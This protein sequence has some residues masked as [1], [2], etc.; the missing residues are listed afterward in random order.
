MIRFLTV[1]SIT[2]LFSSNAFA[3]ACPASSE[4][5]GS[6]SADGSNCTVTG[7]NSTFQLNFIAGFTDTTTISAAGGNNGTTIGAQRKLSFI[8][9]AEILADQI[10]STQT[11][12]V[13]AKF[14]NTLTCDS[15][16][17]TLGSAGASVNSYYPTPPAGITANTW[18][19]VGL[20]NDKA[21]SD[22]FSPAADALGPYGD[23]SESYTGNS[24]GSDINAKFNTDLGDS[25]C[26]SGSNGWY[27]G[28]DSPPSNYIGFVTVL[29]HEMVHGFGF[30]S[31][32]NKS[33]GSK[34]GGLDDIFSNFLYDLNNG[35]WPSLTPAQRADSVVSVTGLLWNGT[36]VN[37]QA[38]GLLTDGFQDNDSSS[39]FT[40]GDRIQMY[41]PNSVEGGSSVSH[42]NTDAS[43][44]ELMEP[45]YT[46]GSLSIGLALYLLQDIG[47]S[48]TA[49]T[50][51]NAPTI[52]AVDQST[53]E[54]TAL[55]IDI[56][57][58][59]LD[60]ADDTDG[61][62]LT[63]TV[64][65]C[66]TNIACSINTDGTNFVMT[67]A[68]NHNGGTHTIT[69]NVSDGNGGTD[70]DTF[71]LNVIAQNDAPQWSTIS[72]QTVNYGTPVDINLSSFASDQEGDSLNYSAT[73]CGT[74]LTC[75]I[76]GS[77]LTLTASSN[78]GN[79]VGVTIQ[80]DDGNSGQTS[81]SF[82]VNITNTAPVLSSIGNQA[83][84]VN[85]NLVVT[86]SA[87]DGEENALT[88]S[89][90]SDA[91]N[92]ATVSGTILTL[93]SAAIG[94]FSVTVQVSDGA[95]TDSE[96]FTF[97]VYPEP[98]LD[99]NSTTL[100]PNDNTN[101]SNSNTVLDISSVNGAYQYSLDF[102]GNNVDSLLSN[103]GT[104]LT[105]GMPTSG[106]FAGEYVLTFTDDNTGDTYD[107]TFVRSP[108][109]VFSATKLLANQS[110]QTLDIEGGAAATTYTLTS[111]E[112]TLTFKNGNSSVTNITGSSDA[113]SFNKA[114]VTL[115]VGNVIAST[116]VDVTVTSTYET[117]DSSGITL[118]PA[119]THTLIIEN[120]NGDALSGANVALNTTNLSAYNLP[121]SYTSNSQGQLSLT[122]PGNTTDYTAVVS[123]SGYSNQSIT[124]DD[125][126]L[127]QTVTMEEITNPMTLAGQVTALEGLSF[128]NELPV[129]TLVLGDSS[130]VNVPVTRTSNNVVTFSY[131][132]NLAISSVS[133][134]EITHSEG[135]GIIFNINSNS[136][137]TF[138]IFMNSST[139]VVTNAPTK[140]GSS[141]GSL[142]AWLFMIL[143][144]LM[145]KPLITRLRNT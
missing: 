76:S 66:A 79:T 44:N 93:S 45:E 123:L 141:G 3:D 136:S 42:F 27:Y 51:N 57:S 119:R 84:P 35:P 41:A 31:L 75:D 13:D 127:T 78:A 23:S 72:T 32:V 98:S 17:A 16:S 112:T 63:F 106:Q 113:S 60:W 64:A 28:F 52:T 77:T 46:E 135:I 68:A 80:A 124:L 2:L 59:G 56:S 121:A 4:A 96:T 67:P 71:N 142:G 30:S 88:Y 5:E 9:A 111:S 25:D 118:E 89:E 1:L 107:F 40:S 69:I 87:T 21:N 73:A 99:L 39:S 117:V 53:N 125:L 65:S 131:V 29:L 109:L 90:T 50:A 81:T 104:N 70:S 19:P 92:V 102:A 38:V 144:L 43:P 108:R 54:D 7:S 18:Y 97:T 115:A 110:I 138:D 114:S 120:D 128:A 116:S 55:T 14:T 15:D 26:L 36:N 143:S 105:I 48:I 11:I 122:L 20:I 86:L 49:P 33:D 82:N 61:D 24:T 58:G 145:Y 95:L 130:E 100:S 134:L 74:G 101:I 91:N 37:N 22:T 34:L 6:G 10:S 47:W 103:S 140:A 133:R 83:A 85:T 126:A 62:T 137:L 94:N 8:K 139:Q 132:H 129:L 12:I